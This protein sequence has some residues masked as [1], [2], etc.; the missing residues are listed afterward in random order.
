MNRCIACIL[1]LLGVASLVFGII[2]IIQSNSGK[3]VVADEINPITLSELNAKY[4]AVKAGQIGRMAAEEPL[5][6]TGQAQPT[7]M[8]D[9]LSAQRGLLGLAKANIA[10]AGFVQMSGIVDIVIGV[11]LIL[12]GLGLLKQ[13]KPP[14][15]TTAA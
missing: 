7:V 1:A 10:L 14:A 9:Y 13:S 8:Y 2:F 4:D 11:G 12:A 6:Q 15:K 5:I 3:Q